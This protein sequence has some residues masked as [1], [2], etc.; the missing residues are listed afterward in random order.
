MLDSSIKQEKVVAVVVTYNRK[1]LLLECIDHLLH[2]RESD[3]LD[4]LVIDNASSDGTESALSDL[5]KAREIIY[6]NTGANIGGAGGFSYGL[7][8]SAELGYKFAWLMDDDCMPEPTALKELLDADK[9]L[10]GSYGFLSSRV[11]WRDRSLCEMNVQR[12]S[13]SRRVRDFDSPLVP[14]ILASFVSF[15]IPVS[16]VYQFGLPIAEFFVWT[17][18]WEYTRRISRKLSCYLVNKSVVIHKSA[19]N[20][21]ASVA[22]DDVSRLGRFK[23]MFRNDVVLYRREGLS[24]FGYEIARICAHSFRVLTRAN[25]HKLVRLDAIFGGTLEGLSFHP[26]IEYVEEKPRA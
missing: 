9:M 5:I 1:E 26:K 14:I 22:D 23:T 2:Q 20:I 6:E 18:D 17:D 21:G 10:G 15:F 4:I 19:N 3:L 8:R 16:V 11:L 13:L 24:G 25:D 7:K 12:Q